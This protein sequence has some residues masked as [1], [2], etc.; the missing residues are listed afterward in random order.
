MQSI[1]NFGICLTEHILFFFEN[2]IVFAYLLEIFKIENE[3]VSCILHNYVDHLS[4]SL[5]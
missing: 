5:F 2:V 3:S 4:K 1:L